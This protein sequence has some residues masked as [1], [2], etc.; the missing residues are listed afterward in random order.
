MLRAFTLMLIASL[1]AALPTIAVAQDAT[2]DKNLD[3]RSSVGDLHVGGDADAKR[4]GLPLY[5]GARLRVDEQNHDQANLS[6]FTEGFG[7][8][9]IVAN[10]ASDDAP[11]KIIDFYRN[12][13]KKYGAVL[14]CR[15][16]KPGGDIDVHDGKD[17]GKDSSANTPVKCDENDG[18]VVELKVGTENDQHIVAVEPADFG[19]G[20]T[21][22]LV[23]VHTRGKQGEI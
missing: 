21:F 2:Q 6:V 18:P 9:L 16:H 10:Y 20:S 22:A 17:D 11:A 15:S 7:L 23:Y 5:P 19:K 1:A 12:K 8:K 4:A 3:I 14:E 13:L